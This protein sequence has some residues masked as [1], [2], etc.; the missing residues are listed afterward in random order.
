VETLGL[1]R[2]TSRL[3]KDFIYKGVI[4]SSTTLILIERSSIEDGSFIKVEYNPLLNE[5]QANII[6]S[7]DI[8][9]TS[10]DIT[11][12]LKTDIVRMPLLFTIAFGFLFW[13]IFGKRMVDLLWD[14]IMRALANINERLTRRR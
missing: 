3:I 7:D 13:R 2:R 4:L 8:K 5:L 1:R 11:D 14:K 9:I 6:A 10:P 12:L